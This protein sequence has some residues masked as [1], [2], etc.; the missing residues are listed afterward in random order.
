MKFQA[1]GT[2]FYKLLLGRGEDEL[3]EVQRVRVESHLACMLL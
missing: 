3:K 2:V 1:G